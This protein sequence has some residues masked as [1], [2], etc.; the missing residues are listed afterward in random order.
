MRVLRYIIKVFRAYDYT[1]KLI[2]VIALFVLLGMLVKLVVFPYGLFSFGE[3]N[4][5]TEGMVSRN[6]FQNINP[7]FVD[8]NEA[9]REVSRLVFS[10]LMKYDPEKRAVVD[11]MA[12][13]SINEDKTEYTFMLREG[14]KWHDGKDLTAD[15]VYFTFH[16]V[17][18]SPSFSNEI[19]KTNFAGVDIEQLDER[20][21][22]FTLEKPNVFFI[23]NLTTGVLPKHILEDTDPYDIL[24][25][26]FNK[27]P[28]GSGPYMISDP[29]EA[30]PDGRTQITLQRS[31]VY[32]NAP[33]DIE[34]IRFI[35]YPTMEQLLEGINSVNGVIK[36]SGKFVNDFENNERFDLFSYELPQYT[37]VFMNMESE[38]LKGDKNV[39]LALQKSLN[40][41][42]L[43]SQFTDKKAVD[44]PLME[45]DQ[46]EWVY[47]PNVEEAEGALKDSGYNY[48][49]D[50]TEKVG[51][52]YDEDGAAL[53]LNFIARLYSEGSPQY[54]E[55]KTVV[56]FL[57][58]SWEA[59]GMNI[60]VEFLPESDFKDR[61][62]TRAYDLLL[63]GQNLGYNLDTYSYWHSTQANPMGQN[64]SNYKSFRVDSLIED[65]RSV[66]NQEK[67][68]REL[69]EL[70]EQIKDDIPAIFLYRPVY[71]YASDGKVSGVSMNGVVFASDRFVAM[72]LWKFER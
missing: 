56:S 10:G 58:D 64:L 49:E 48:A 22:K 6:G 69:N 11:D 17:V 38:I 62:K 14:L 53:E 1:D 34:F 24:K 70:A 7:L 47:Q 3:S 66:F 15:D 68:E 54:E 60:N 5:Y 33:S 32:Y 61:T 30:F 45:L 36:I 42:D 71:Y 28:V 44:T 16:D 67:R 65:I 52:R 51:I 55:A 29:V 25:H 59:V 8:Y 9:D 13:L 18:L 72:P 35:S 23:T 31:P 40:K 4:I 37:A 57:Q 2:S 12:V 20:S 19:L 43:I 46:E 27:I 21:I 50:D 41:E 63:V 39:R 26:E